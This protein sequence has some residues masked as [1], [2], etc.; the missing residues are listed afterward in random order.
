MHNFIN[1]LLS[2]SGT[3]SCVRFLHVVSI[4]TAAAIAIMGIVKDKDLSQVSILCSTFIVPASA[5]K[6]F[7]KN[8]ETK[9]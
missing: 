1:N 8:M 9:A 4:F 2:E 7:Q 5:A 3:I 6:V